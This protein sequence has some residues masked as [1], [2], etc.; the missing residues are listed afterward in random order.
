MM[1]G[2]R[3]KDRRHKKRSTKFR[4][5]ELP[6]TIIWIKFLPN[7]HVTSSLDIRYSG[8][9]RLEVKYNYKYRTVRARIRLTKKMEEIFING[10][11]NLA[12]SK[13]ERRYFF[14]MFDAKLDSKKIKER[15]NWQAYRKLDEKE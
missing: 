14:K 6:M 4:F 10:G 13:N 8:Y 7:N 3:K 12:I 1:F 9:E 5:K 2:T 11:S 15:Y